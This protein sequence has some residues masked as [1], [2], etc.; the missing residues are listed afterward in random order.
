MVGNQTKMLNLTGVKRKTSRHFAYSIFTKEFLMTNVFIVVKKNLY[1][2]Y[3]INKDST[4]QTAKKH[5]VSLEDFKII[6]EVL[7]ERSITEYYK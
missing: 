3:V 1:K 5:N 4:L 7:Y 6:K 2:E